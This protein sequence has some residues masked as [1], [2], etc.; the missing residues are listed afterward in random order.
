MVHLG[1]PLKLVGFAEQFTGTIIVLRASPEGTLNAVTNREEL[2][3]PG[4]TYTWSMFALVNPETGRA[5]VQAV[6]EKPLPVCKDG[7][8]WV[9]E[10]IRELNHEPE[11]HRM[12]TQGPYLMQ[13]HLGPN[14]EI[15]M[16]RFKEHDQSNAKAHAGKNLKPRDRVMPAIRDAKNDAGKLDP[17]TITAHM[18]AALSSI[19]QGE[20]VPG[21]SDANDG[22]AMTA[23]QVAAASSLFGVHA[24][25]G[26]D[27]CFIAAKKQS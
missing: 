1:Y 17:S 10:K 20:Y 23:A 2:Y 12:G 26:W 8:V 25:E 15:T 27:W 4:Y 7:V 11:W 6:A 24:Q 3:T 5:E 9:A 13:Q 19:Q 14:G 22:E 21:A 16:A 18:S